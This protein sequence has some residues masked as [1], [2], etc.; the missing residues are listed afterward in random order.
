MKIGCESNQ[1]VTTYISLHLQLLFEIMTGYN[2]ILFNYMIQ[3]LLMTDSV[4]DTVI[5][6]RET[7]IKK[8]KFL[9]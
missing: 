6:S 8:T 3:F 5:N 2:S 9:P 1:C 4:Q 7:K